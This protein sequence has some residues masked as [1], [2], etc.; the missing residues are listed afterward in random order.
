ASSANVFNLDQHKSLEAGA[1]AF[2]PKPL[3]MDQLF[4]KIE[5][6]LKVEWIHE[7]PDGARAASEDL[8]DSAEPI[9]LSHPDVTLPSAEELAALL[10]FAHKGLINQIQKQIDKLDR[11][12]PTLAPF[13]RH[14]RRLSKDFRLDAIEEFLKKCIDGR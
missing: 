13:V 12:D 2:L 10:D 7:Q 1:N 5:Q 3:E 4:Q 14:L 8:R 11:S 9:D 6:H